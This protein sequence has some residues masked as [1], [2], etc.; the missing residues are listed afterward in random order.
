MVAY[1]IWNPVQL[2]HR[3]QAKDTRHADEQRN[4]REPAGGGD[5]HITPLLGSKQIAARIEV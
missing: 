5:D 1:N 4:H 2:E 3:Y